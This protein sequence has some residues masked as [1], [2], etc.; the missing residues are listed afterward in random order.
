MA[1]VSDEVL[2]QFRTY[3]FQASPLNSVRNRERTPQIYFQFHHIK[4]LIT[5]SKWVY[6]FVVNNGM[7]TKIGHD[8]KHSILP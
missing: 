6:I 4:M 5:R 7:L 3:C 8:D 2:Q 1:F